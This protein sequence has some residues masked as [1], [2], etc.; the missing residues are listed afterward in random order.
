MTKEG[1]GQ[2]RRT[3]LVQTVKKRNAKAGI[4]KAMEGETET[5]V[6]RQELSETLTQNNFHEHLQ[7]RSRSKASFVAILR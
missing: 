3:G 2:I 7:L 5:T 6:E 1:N 4:S